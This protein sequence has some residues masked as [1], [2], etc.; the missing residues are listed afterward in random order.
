MFFTLFNHFRALIL[1]SLIGFFE[2]LILDPKYICLQDRDFAT[3]AEL[4]MKDSNQFH[5]VCQAHAYKHHL[6]FE[7]KQQWIYWILNK[8]KTTTQLRIARSY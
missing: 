4:T 5:A 7:R 8:T 2:G 3:F 1:S 6:N